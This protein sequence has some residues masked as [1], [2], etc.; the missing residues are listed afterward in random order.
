MISIGST[1]VEVKLK[2]LRPTQMTVG[3]KEVEK[4]R[5]SWEKLKADDCRQA[6]RQE[7]FPAVKG[8]GKSFYILDHHHKAVALLRENSAT[9]QVGVVK[10]L[11]M[12]KPRDFWIFLDHYSWVHPYD[13]AGERRAFKDMPKNFE[14]LKDD[15][16]RSLAGEVRDAGGFAKSDA[17]FLD[18]LWANHLRIWSPR[19][20]LENTPDEALSDALAL[21]RSKKS[22]HLPGWPGKA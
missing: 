4:K 10:D 5:K 11:S 2:H 15:P 1:L 22:A 6:M 7:L 20:R 9:V 13:E 8:P 14:E 3:F 16:Y 12:L 19:K 21:A 18:F 17:P